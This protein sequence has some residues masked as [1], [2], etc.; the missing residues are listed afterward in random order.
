MTA[1]GLSSSIWRPSI[2]NVVAVL[3]IAIPVVTA[4]G[5]IH[6]TCQVCDPSNSGSCNGF[7]ASLP[8]RTGPQIVTTALVT[9][10]LSAWQSAGSGQG[11]LGRGLFRTVM[12]AFVPEVALFRLHH[13]GYAMYPKFEEW[14]IPTRAE[15][16]CHEFRPTKAQII[17]VYLGL[18]AV[19]DESP[20][21][22]KDGRS[23]PIREPAGLLRFVASSTGWRDVK[24]DHDLQPGYRRVT[25]QEAV[26]LPH[27]FHALPK[28]RQTVLG[29]P[30]PQVAM[31][32]LLLQAIYYI[33]Y[34]VA[35]AA[36]S[37]YTT[38]IEWFFIPTS[39]TLVALALAAILW[40]P[41][42]KDI[43]HIN[44]NLGPPLDDY[45][46]SRTNTARLY[47]GAVV[48][49]IVPIGPITT[50]V[51]FG[52]EVHRRPKGA[53]PVLAAM[54]II[55]AIG[56]VFITA[57]LL[58][59]HYKPFGH[60]KSIAAPPRADSGTGYYYSLLLVIARAV[61]FGVAIYELSDLPAAAYA[62]M[63]WSQYL[64]HL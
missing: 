36:Q 9:G 21:V 60:R 1:V 5:V 27:L 57:L 2:W 17:A 28:G 22:E 31:V 62:Q 49:L 52:L 38:I 23:G 15:T 47:F 34:V 45:P 20:E 12:Q 7:L 16:R 43:A 39:C 4:T 59:G 29:S 40:E 46:W 63:S 48:S 25:L 44:I 37:L 58:K 35:R 55:W 41:A 33:A 32:L 18:L 64:P 30:V 24:F 50:L 19:R 11:G 13:I 3:S 54:G 51:A 10:I 26:Y 53:S 42:W 14:I 8:L 61:T 6:A 56:F